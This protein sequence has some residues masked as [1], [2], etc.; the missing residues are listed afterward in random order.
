MTEV[1]FFVFLSWWIKD[2]YSLPPLQQLF[3]FYQSDNM[4]TRLLFISLFFSSEH[5]GTN[6][7]A[8]TISPTLFQY[9]PSLYTSQARH[10]L[11]EFCRFMMY[12]SPPFLQKYLK[13][14]LAC[15]MLSASCCHC[16]GG[17]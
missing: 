9:C 14:F 12:I 8:P 15:L 1:L 5:S 7:D 11:D 2:H 16:G 10:V 6:I 4:F 17:L 13:M 3:M